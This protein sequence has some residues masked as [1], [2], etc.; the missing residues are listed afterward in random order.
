MLYER[1]FHT[2]YLAPKL[3]T[4]NSFVIFGAKILYEKCAR[5]T[6]TKLTPAFLESIWSRYNN[7][8]LSFVLIQLAKVKILKI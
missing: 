1:V 6:L 5:K 4:Q 2:K 7:I 8:L 3:Q